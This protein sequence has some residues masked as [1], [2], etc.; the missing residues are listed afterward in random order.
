MV[1]S[2]CP[3]PPT[4]IFPRNRHQPLRLEHQLSEINRSTCRLAYRTS[5]VPYGPWASGGWWFTCD[6]CL[7]NQTFVIY[8]YLCMY[9]YIYIMHITYIYMC[10]CMQ[11]LFI[12]WRFNHE[13]WCF[14]AASH[15]VSDPAPPSARGGLKQWD[16]RSTLPTLRRHNGRLAPGSRPR[17]FFGE[18]RSTW[19]FFTIHWH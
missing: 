3:K 19:G 18:G 12:F 7:N 1:K 11:Y 10:V 2:Q 14:E 17:R 6:T 4:L 8:S 5:G 13:E 16:L 15:V 9:N